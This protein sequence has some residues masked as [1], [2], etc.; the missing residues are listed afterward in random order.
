MRV[1]GPQLQDWAAAAIRKLRGRRK[2]IR[3]PAG[4]LCFR[5]SNARLVIDDE[6]SVIR[7]AK[8]SFPAGVV[9]TE[10]LRKA[11]IYDHFSQTGEVPPK[12]HVEPAADQFLIT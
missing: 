3:L 1:Y 6:S 9:M 10:K 5:R 11:A 2:S 4:S 8:I 7:W 12:S